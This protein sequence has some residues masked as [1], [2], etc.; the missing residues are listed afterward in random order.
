MEITLRDIEEVVKMPDDFPKG[1][2]ESSICCCR[3]IRS[4]AGIS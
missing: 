3:D 2:K 4:D 1:W